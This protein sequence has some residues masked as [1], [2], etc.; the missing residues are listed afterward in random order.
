MADEFEQPN[1][2]VVNAELFSEDAFPEDADEAFATAE[3][4]VDAD[5]LLITTEPEPTPLGRSW[6]FDFET[7]RFVMA[8][9]APIET[10]RTQTLRYWIEKCLRT[11]QGGLIIEPPDY[12]FE[13]PT[14]VFGDQFD[15]ADVATLEERVREAL[16]FHPAISDIEN[17]DLAPDPEDEEVALMRFHVV[18]DDQT[19]LEL[20]QAL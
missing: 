12:G 11:P 8:G 13:K 19:R 14:N 7:K 18:L 2:E 1:P 10:R 20:N 3:E 15:S 16:L 6:A 9:H 5:E 4:N 17:F